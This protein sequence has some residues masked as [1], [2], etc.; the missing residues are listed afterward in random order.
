MYWSLL[1]LSTGSVILPNPGHEESA[2]DES[3]VDEPALGE[4]GEAVLD[5]AGEAVLGDGG[6]GEG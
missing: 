1:P 3:S 2:L 4:G 5:D 6:E